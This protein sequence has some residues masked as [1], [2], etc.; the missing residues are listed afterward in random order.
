V[1]PWCLEYGIVSTC[2]KH[3]LTHPVLMLYFIKTLSVPAQRQSLNGR[4]YAR[5]GNES[6]HTQERAGAIMA[7]RNQDSYSCNHEIL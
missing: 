2:F 5:Q 7:F 4:S 3:E 6:V 1:Y